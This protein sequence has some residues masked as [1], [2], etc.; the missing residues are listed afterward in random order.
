MLNAPIGY[1]FYQ[2]LMHFENKPFIT[3]KITMTQSQ[4]KDQLAKLVSESKSLDVAKKTKDPSLAKHVYFDRELNW[5]CK[6]CPYA[7]KCEKMRLA[8]SKSPD[9]IQW[10]SPIDIHQSKDLLNIGNGNGKGN[11]S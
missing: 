6:D 11:H 4:R 2:C 5:L 8:I 7:Q 1:M 10:Q 9:I 3:F